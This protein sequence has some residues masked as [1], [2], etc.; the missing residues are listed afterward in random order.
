MGLWHTHEWERIH[1][2]YGTFSFLKGDATQ[3]T[4]RCPGCGKIE[5]KTLNGHIPADKLGLGRESMPARPAS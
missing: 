1:V 5:Q 3:I 4:W 2:M